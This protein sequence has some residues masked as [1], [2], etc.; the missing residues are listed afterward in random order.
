MASSILLMNAAGYLRRAQASAIIALTAREE[1]RIWSV[2]EN[3]SSFGKDL[4]STKIFLACSRAA[5]KLPNYESFLLS[6]FDPQSSILHPRF[7]IFGFLSSVWLLLR[8]YPSLHLRSSIIE[9]YLRYSC[10]MK[11]EESNSLIKLGSTNVLGSA[12]AAFGFVRAR[13]SS[14]VFTPSGVG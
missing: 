6:P 13:S 14:M 7:F 12:A 11:P 3:R 9:F 2:S 10:L 1:R 5:H 8:T 4:E